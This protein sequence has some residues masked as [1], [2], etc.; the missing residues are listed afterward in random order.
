MKLQSVVQRGQKLVQATLRSQQIALIASRYGILEGLATLGIEV[1]RRG[2]T[3]SRVK[4]YPKNS[5]DRVFGKNLAQTFVKLGPS[6][7]KLGQML[8]VRPDLVGEGIADELRVLFYGVPAISYAKILRILNRELGRDCVKKWF[9]SIDKKPLAC[10]SLAQVHRAILRGGIPVVLKVQ[11]PGVAELV[12][13]DLLILETFARSAHQVI[14]HWGIWQ[15]FKDYKEAALREVDYREE[16]KNIDRFRRNYKKLFSQSDV[17]FPRYF[18]TLTTSRVLVL[19]PMHGKKVAELK[20]GSTVARRAATLSVQAL[21][22][23]IFDHGFFH[24]D[25]HGG[26]LFFLEKNDKIG[27]ID[28]GMVGHLEPEDKL[29]FLKVL[30]AVLKRDRKNLASALYNLGIPGKRTKYEKFEKDVQSLLDKVKKKGVTNVRLDELINQLL[31][32]AK[33]NKIHIPNRYVLMI[34]SFLIIEGVAK[35]LD[36]KISLFKLAPPIV[37]KSLLKS[38]NPFRRFRS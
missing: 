18:P 3:L 9:S 36:P 15:V 16:A 24:A 6:F 32:V 21:L 11:K 38:Y 4:K 7:I 37:A 28:L 1:G 35:E 14:P 29:K 19:E 13:L 27:F 17:I 25:P 22:E 34:R 8:A 10:A 12:K 2:L 26:N 20:K 5:L 31:T 33:K 23:Q 30:M